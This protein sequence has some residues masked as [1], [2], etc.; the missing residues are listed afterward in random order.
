M[1]RREALKTTAGLIA[2]AIGGG[3][4][5][6]INATAKNISLLRPPGAQEKGKFQ[7]SCIRCG[8]CVIAC[9]FDTLFLAQPGDGAGAGTPVFKP[10]NQPCKMCTDIPCTFACPTDALSIDLLKD[11]NSKANINKARMGIAIVDSQHCIAY[12]GIRC[13]E[14]YR[15]CPLIDKAIKLDYRHNERTGSHAMF[16]P[17]VDPTVCTG[18]GMC[19][20]ACITKEAS[21]IILPREMVQGDISKDYIKGWQPEDEKRIDPDTDFTKALKNSK[22]AQDYLNSGDEL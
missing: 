12:S 16:I 11:E 3:T 1:K 9:P 17:V 18:C 15:V 13:D 10:R 21:I 4:I 2:F 19:E 20:R 6:S 14:C 8:L 5:W 7:S 22:S